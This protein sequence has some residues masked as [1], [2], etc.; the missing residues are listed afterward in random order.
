MSRHH[1]ISG[2]TLNNRCRLLLTCVVL[3]ACSASSFA[4]AT[5]VYIT[6]N[7]LTQGGCTSYPQTPAW[8]NN[9]S[10]WGSGANQIGP[11]TTVLL[12]GSFVDATPGDTLLNFKGGGT[13]GSPITL[14]FDTNASLTNTAYWGFVNNGGGAI[15]G[16]THTYTTINGGTNG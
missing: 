14:L 5:K 8:F 2:G 12:C 16:G 9:S 4:S 10:N 7:G 6:P 13:S 15:S 3:F 11:G 1:S